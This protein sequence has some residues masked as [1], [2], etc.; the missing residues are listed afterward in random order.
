MNSTKL[1]GIIALL[2]SFALL[3]TGVVLVW[4]GLDAKAEVRAALVAENIVTPDDA[5]IPGVPVDSAA[6]AM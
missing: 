5:S 2:L 4:Q 1:P 6:T 3:G